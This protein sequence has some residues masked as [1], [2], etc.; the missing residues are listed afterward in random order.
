MG[1][2]RPRRG[3]RPSSDIASRMHGRQ[4]FQLLQTVKNIKERYR[5]I[6]LFQERIEG[7]QHA[8]AHGVLE[9]AYPVYELVYMTD[10]VIVGGFEPLAREWKE[11]LEQLHHPTDCHVTKSIFRSPN[12]ICNLDRASIYAG[13]DLR[14][15][16]RRESDENRPGGCW[17]DYPEVGKLLHGVGCG[18]HGP[19][20]LQRDDALRYIDQ[21]LG[22]DLQ[23]PLAGGA[24]EPI[25][26]ELRERLFIFSSEL[27]DIEKR[28]VYVLSLAEEK[29]FGKFRASR[30]MS[31]VSSS[32][33]T[34]S[35]R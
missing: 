10:M 21:D 5:R 11:I 32:S 35:T 1:S 27:E 16:V 34:T 13:R 19:R 17:R 4:N 8:C 26:L 23:P 33:K 31:R 15:P 12:D 25:I 28:P 22:G 30:S 9:F 20:I 14:H 18:T 29:R 6:R 7:G 24:E 2:F 3:Y